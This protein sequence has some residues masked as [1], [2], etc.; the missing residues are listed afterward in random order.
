MRTLRI[1]NGVV[2]ATILRGDEILPPT[3]DQVL[4]EGDHLVL[5]AVP[6]AVGKVEGLFRG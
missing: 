2:I 5:F 1:P 3:G 4:R 6:E